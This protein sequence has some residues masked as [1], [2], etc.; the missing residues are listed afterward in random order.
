M[1]IAD[2]R[3][4]SSTPAGGHTFASARSVKYAA[5]RPPKNMS[6]DA[7]HTTAPT[8]SIDGCCRAGLSVVAPS[9]IVLPVAVASSH[10]AAH[11]LAHWRRLARVSVPG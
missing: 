8:A 2:R 4:S 5:N 11:R 3:V 6:S 10:R 7:S 1:K 9:A